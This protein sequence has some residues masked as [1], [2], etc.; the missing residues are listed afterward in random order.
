MCS[1]ADDLPS[2]AS[3]WISRRELDRLTVRP[4]KHAAVAVRARVDFPVRENHSPF[5]RDTGSVERRS[6]GNISIPR[7]SNSGRFRR[8]SGASV[9]GDA[10]SDSLGGASSTLSM[11]SGP[12]ARSY[13]I[14]SRRMSR[15][16]A[17]SICAP[18]GS[19]WCLRRNRSHR[20][21]L[22]DARRSRCAGPSVRRRFP[23]SRG[24][25]SNARPRPPATRRATEGFSARARRGPIA[26]NPRRH[27]KSSAENRAA[28]RRA[29]ARA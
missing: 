7:D 18:S 10:V 5:A 16:A 8:M 2:S 11:V 3:R 29:C 17:R 28:S 1:C 20:R 23:S 24:S 14:P 13:S 12:L 25:S 15:A 26:P 9:R 22:R 21:S 27:R 4:R 19:T 6:R